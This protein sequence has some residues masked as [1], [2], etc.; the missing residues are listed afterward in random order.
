MHHPFVRHRN[1]S[2]ALRCLPEGSVWL[3]IHLVS[4]SHPFRFNLFLGSVATSIEIT[5]CLKLSKLRVEANHRAV[6][7][8]AHAVYHHCQDDLHDGC[9]WSHP[10]AKSTRSFPL[11]PVLP[12]LLRWTG[13]RS[14]QGH[15]PRLHQ[16]CFRLRP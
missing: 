5:V 9:R 11:L 16:Q 14:A 7:A 13:P 15:S 2:L 12:W 10:D 6:V 1:N 8:I 3:R 4:S